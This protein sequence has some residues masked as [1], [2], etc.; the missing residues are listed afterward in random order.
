[1]FQ[2]KQSMKV[3]RDMPQ[4]AE[5][6]RG[7][8]LSTLSKECQELATYCQCHAFTYV[9]ALPE[10]YNEARRAVMALNT[11]LND[12]GNYDD[13]IEMYV[14]VRHR[15]RMFIKLNMKHTSLDQSNRLI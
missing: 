13:F 1:M 4:R 12:D 7:I 15:F 8:I 10:C 5:D 3:L 6:S 14:S 2:V 9:F 11:W